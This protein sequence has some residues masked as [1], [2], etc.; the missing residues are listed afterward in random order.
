MRLYEPT[1]IGP[2]CR[3]GDAHIYYVLHILSREGI[4]SRRRLAETLGIG[5]GSV[6][7]IIS[8]L[9]NWELV[10]VRQS[11]V[12]LTEDGRTF[13]RDISMKMVDAPHSDYVL[14]AFQQGIV[15][16]GVSDRITDG[17]YQRD[18]GII[19]GATGASVF[20]M[21]D[22]AVIMP[23]CWNM[24]YRDPEFAAG[25]RGIGL[26][27]DDVLVISGASDRDTATISAIAI[28]LDLL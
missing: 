28:G 24:D 20:L 25:V 7:Q 11:G 3:F 8:I 16:N 1:S 23:S 18:R 17:M 22:D 19:A 5:E 10:A 12:Y 9:R 6:R 14:G 21:R 26:G 15:V 27:E 4:V 2:A 13:L